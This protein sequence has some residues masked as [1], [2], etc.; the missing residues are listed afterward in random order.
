MAAMKGPFSS[1]GFRT[2]GSLGV[3]TPPFAVPQ[4]YAER[5]AKGIAVASRKLYNAIKNKGPA[6]PS[7][8]DVIGFRSIQTMGIELGEMYREIYPADFACW[9]EKGWMDKSKYYYTE[10]KI[11]PVN[12]AIARVAVA[13]IMLYLRRTLFAEAGNRTATNPDITGDVHGDRRTA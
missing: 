2:A 12:K 4:K 5:N 9:K 8:T 7:L 1:F 6:R 10:A 11:S 3:M 13:S